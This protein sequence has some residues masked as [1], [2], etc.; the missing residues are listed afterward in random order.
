MD[1]SKLS[2]QQILSLEQRAEI[3]CC[4]K[5]YT[6]DGNGNH[7]K[8]AFLAGASLAMK[9]YGEEEVWAEILKRPHPSGNTYFICKIELI[10]SPFIVLTKEE[11]ELWANSGDGNYYEEVKAYIITEK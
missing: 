9:E 5:G 11:A 8:A 7:M 3:Y 2:R 4:H 10:G 6:T 1:L